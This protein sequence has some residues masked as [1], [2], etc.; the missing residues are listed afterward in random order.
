ML[1]QGGERAGAE[2]EERENVVSAVE[3]SVYF[4][5]PLLTLRFCFKHHLHYRMY[6]VLF[7]DLNTNFKFLITNFKNLLTFAPRIKL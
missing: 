4:A 7:M 5:L 3:N 2:G 6:P 1:I